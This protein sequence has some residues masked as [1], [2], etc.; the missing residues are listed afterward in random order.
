[1]QLEGVNLRRVEIA[2]WSCPAA[3]Q[4][5]IRSLPALWLYDGRSLI[6]T[7]GRDVMMRLIAR[8]DG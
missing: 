5:G 2:D 6:S 1:M 3:E 8:R 4:H 7:A